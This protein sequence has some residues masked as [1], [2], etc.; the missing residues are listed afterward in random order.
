MLLQEPFTS[1]RL[2]LEQTP[3]GQPPVTPEGFSVL[4]IGLAVAF[5]LAAIAII[6]F[7]DPLLTGKIIDLIG[8]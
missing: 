8:N 2:L 1:S 3:S 6:L 4:F 7:D 5:I